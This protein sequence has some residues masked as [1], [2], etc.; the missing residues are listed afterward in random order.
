MGEREKRA[1]GTGRGK[2]R[3]EEGGRRG[4][5]WDIIECNVQI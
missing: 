4:E 3:E 1:R 2:G 5:E